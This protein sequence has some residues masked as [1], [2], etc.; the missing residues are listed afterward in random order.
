VIAEKGGA[1]RAIPQEAF[2]HARQSKV[3][4]Q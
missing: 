1:S 3:M 2:P 4:P